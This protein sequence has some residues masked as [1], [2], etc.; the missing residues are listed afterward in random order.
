MR[1]QL[2]RHGP[3]NPRGCTPGCSARS[4][5]AASPHHV[6]TARHMEAR[7]SP[8]ARTPHGSG[9]IAIVDR[10]A[11]ARPQR[12]LEQLPLAARRPRRR[13]CAARRAA[14]RS[15]AILPYQVHVSAA[16]CSRPRSAGD[17]G[18]RRRHARQGQLRFD[19]R[20]R[21]PLRRSRQRQWRG[22]LVAARDLVG[23]GHATGINP[24][25]AARRPAGEREL[26]TRGGRGA[27]SIAHGDTQRR[28]QQ[29]H[30]ASCA[31]RARAA[32]APSRTRARPGAST[33]VRVGLGSTSLAL[34]G[35]VDDAVEPAL[36]AR[37]PQDLRLLV[38]AAAAVS[39]PRARCAARRS[40]PA[41]IAAAHGQGRELRGHQDSRASMRTSTSIPDAAEQRVEDR[42]AA[43]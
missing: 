22:D 9:T 10:R 11:A 32:A 13:R 41:V 21:R 36:R 15:Q 5:P 34:D 37:R 3:V 4:S 19:A 17:A 27:A 16:S 29:P 28:L 6:L 2:Q 14:S 24:G 23:G 1:D 31:A 25:A 33:I 42:R 20:G 7:H 30:A 38:R 12:Q 26:R 43:A 18:R 40:D 8:P 39:K 35:R